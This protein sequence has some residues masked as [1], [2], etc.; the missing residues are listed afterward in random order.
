LQYLRRKLEG[1]KYINRKTS[2]PEGSYQSV[3]VEKPVESLRKLKGNTSK[4]IPP[5]PL[6]ENTF[7]GS[8]SR[9]KSVEGNFL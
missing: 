9:R 3:V 4:K 2:H 1:S 7:K 6:E 8:Q 5:V